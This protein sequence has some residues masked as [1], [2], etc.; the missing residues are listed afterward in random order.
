MSG[1]INIAEECHVVPVI[2]PQDGNTGVTGDVFSMREYSHASI[3][4]TIGTSAVA[5][6]KLL[7]KE[8]AS[9]AGGGT[10]IAYDSYSGTTTG[11]AANADVLSERVTAATTTTAGVSLA[12]TDNIFYVIEIDAAQLT[13]GYEWIEVSFTADAGVNYVSCIAILSG[14]RYAGPASR[15]VLDN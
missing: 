8:C 10:L 15:T 14:S 12:E 6:T 5:M 1:H 9:K 7:V 2:Y 3:I 13:A 11:A 4:F